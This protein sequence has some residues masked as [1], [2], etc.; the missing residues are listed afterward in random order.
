[1]GIGPIPYML[2]NFL[3]SEWADELPWGG[4]IQQVYIRF[5]DD[6]VPGLPDGQPDLDVRY[7]EGQASGFRNNL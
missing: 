5:P 4:R 6:F 7:G 3:I 2:R 1:M